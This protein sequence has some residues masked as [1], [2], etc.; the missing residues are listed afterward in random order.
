MKWRELIQAVFDS[1][2]RPQPQPPHA[3]PGYTP[4]TDPVDRVHG[5][6]EFVTFAAVQNGR[7]LAN[8]EHH[9]RSGEGLRTIRATGRAVGSSGS[10]ATLRRCSM[11]KP[12][13][14]IHLALCGQSSPTPRSW[15]PSHFGAVSVVVDPVG[16]LA[17]SHRLHRRWL[18]AFDRTFP[19]KARSGFSLRPR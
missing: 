18:F 3:Q 19:L 16:Q 5:E 6:D 4:P 15:C 7:V 12:S 17:M 11:L 8:A 13:N 2:R 1:F 9:F 10:G 14:P